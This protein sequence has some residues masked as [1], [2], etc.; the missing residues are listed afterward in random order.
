M[1]ARDITSDTEL[2]MPWMPQELIDLYV[3]SYVEYGD[4]ELAWAAV[5]QSAAYDRFFPGMKRDD[6]TMR[7]GDEQEYIAVTEAYDDVFRSVGLNPSLWKERYI[8]LLEGDVSPDE[9]MRDRVMPIYER[10]MDQGSEA[11]RQRYADDWGLEMTFESILAAALDPDDIGSR[12]LNRQIALSEIGG[13]AASSGFNVTKEYAERLYEDKNL[14]REQA[15][16]LFQ[17]AETFVP[18]MSVLSARHADPDDDFNLEDFVSAELFSN[19]QQRRRMRR[20]IAQEN[21]AFTGGATIDY[22]RTREGGV[23]GLMDR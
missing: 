19:P 13:E 18:A 8:D 5:R 9:L 11:I 10:L 20:L 14:T 6:G 3:D 4:P 16:L 17:Q 22:L 21:A 2:L 23:A 12:I 15:D 7:F 1:T